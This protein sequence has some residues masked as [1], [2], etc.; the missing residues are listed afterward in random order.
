M[1]PCSTMVYQSPIQI[2]HYLIWQVFRCLQTPA[3][4]KS[5]GLQVEFA[6][7][8][9]K[10]DALD[11]DSHLY[12]IQLQLSQL[13]WSGA[14][15]ITR[16][17]ALSHMH[18]VGCPPSIF[19]GLL[20]E[21][22]RQLDCLKQCKLAWQTISFI[23]VQRHNFKELDNIW[24]NIPF[25]SWE[26]VREVLTILSEFGYEWVPPPPHHPIVGVSVWQLGEFL[27]E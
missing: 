15:H 6:H 4:L 26:I 9:E 10:Q 13:V 20:C 14:L 23:E 2:V 3:D 11:K 7:P 16:F 22:Q 1:W 17:R 18:Y 25:A 27:V 21:G 12:L 24:S 8:S 19:V 5:A